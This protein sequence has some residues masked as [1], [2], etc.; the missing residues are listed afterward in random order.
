MMI[1]YYELLTLIQQGT[2]PDKVILHHY[3]Q[4]IPYVKDLEIDG[5]FKTYVIEDEG[6]LP[7]HEPRELF[8]YLKDHLFDA[9][10]FDKTLE[11][12]SK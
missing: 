11:I 4:R 6:Y 9:D 12:E 10:C 7:S 5:S 3:E 8:V 2:I 1:S